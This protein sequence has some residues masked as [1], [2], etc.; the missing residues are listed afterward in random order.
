MEEELLPVINYRAENERTSLLV[1][2]DRT[3]LCCVDK[4]TLFALGGFACSAIHVMYL[5]LFGIAVINISSDYQLTNGQKNLIL[6]S[7]FL[8]GTRVAVIA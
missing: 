8:F 2:L 6:G 7:F 1:S 4:I 5:A 3:K